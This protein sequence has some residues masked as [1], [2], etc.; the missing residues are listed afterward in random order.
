MELASFN[1]IGRRELNNLIEILSEG[2]ISPLLVVQSLTKKQFKDYNTHIGYLFSIYLYPYY[3]NRNTREEL[4]GSF[5][6]DRSRF[7][8]IRKGKNIRFPVTTL[9]KLGKFILHKNDDISTQNSEDFFTY[10]K[11]HQY[12]DQEQFNSAIFALR[13]LAKILR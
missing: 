9:M 12:E 11:K 2:N 10:L 13:E 4:M 6:I 7:Y 3:E 8:M 5:E 1:M